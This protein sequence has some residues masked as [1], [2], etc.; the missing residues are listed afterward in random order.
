MTKPEPK[1]NT[2]SQELH[3]TMKAKITIIIIVMIMI[4][5]NNY[6]Y[7]YNYYNKLP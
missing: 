5:S 1:L 2:V 6:D 4:M 7:N 3:T